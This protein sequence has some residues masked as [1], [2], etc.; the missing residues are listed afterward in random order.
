MNKKQKIA[1]AIAMSERHCWELI[2]KALR[3]DA[4]AD[5]LRSQG[6]TQ[7]RASRQAQLYL[8]RWRLAIARLDAKRQKL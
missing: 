6:V 3:S 1:D 8:K 7:P 4:E 2:N 5:V